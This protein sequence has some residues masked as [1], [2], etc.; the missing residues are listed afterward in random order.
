M[1]LLDF[2]DYEVRVNPEA[3]LVRPIR[4]LYNEDRSARKEKFFQQMSY[5]YFMCD[6]RSTYNYLV[7][8]EERKRTIIEQEGLPEDFTPSKQLEEAMEWYKKHTVTASQRLLES[9]LIAADTVSTFLRDKTIF[10]KTD[11]KGRPLYQVSS[12]TTALKNVEGIVASLQNLTK[13]VEQ[14]VEDKSRAR[15]GNKAMFEDGVDTFMNK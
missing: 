6:P 7:D 14:E 9:A 2:L 11:D 3:L 10:T 8:E 12:V 1:R 15:G 13:K 5:C 4:R